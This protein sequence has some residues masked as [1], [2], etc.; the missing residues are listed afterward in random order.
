MTFMM[1]GTLRSIHSL[2]LIKCSVGFPI[3]R[4][5]SL[6]QIFEKRQNHS[7]GLA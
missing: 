1:C 7:T 3:L 4:H 2:W 6:T 5:L